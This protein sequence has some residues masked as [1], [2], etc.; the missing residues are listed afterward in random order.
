MNFD[1]DMEDDDDYDYI[2]DED[3]LKRA[4]FTWQFP[5]LGIVLFIIK[6][7]LRPIINFMGPM[8]PLFIDTFAY[9]LLA[10]GFFRLITCLFSY[11]DCIENS[12]IKHVIAGLVVYGICI[13]FI[14]Y[15]YF[16]YNV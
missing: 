6:P 12:A 16:T 1:E 8:A 14:A 2:M 4:K 7:Y 11:K 13:S 9:A 15:A 10:Y 3:L 5:L